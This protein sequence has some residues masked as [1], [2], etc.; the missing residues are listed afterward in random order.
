M[1]KLFILIVG[2]DTFIQLFLINTFFI[3]IFVVEKIQLITRFVILTFF[4]KN[5]TQN[6]YKQIA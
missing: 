1:S 4:P 3:T 2:N 6:L 5:K